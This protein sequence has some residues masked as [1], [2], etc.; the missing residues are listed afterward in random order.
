MK[1]DVEKPLA[2]Y[3]QIKENLLRYLEDERYQTD[4]RLPSESELM[5]H[6]GVSRNT[7]RQAL[8]ELVNEGIIYKK[9]R[10]GSFFSGAIQGA[11]KRSHLIGVITPFLARYIYP[12]IIQGIDDIAHRHHYNLVLGNTRGVLER[13]IATIESLLAKNIDGVLI[14]LSAGFQQIHDSQTFHFVK[15]LTIPLVFL[16]WRIDDPDVSY[17]SVNDVEGGFRATSYLA[18][19]GHTRIACVYPEDHIAALHRYQGYRNALEYYHL[20]YDSRLDKAT[21]VS[22]WDT[23][24]MNTPIQELLDLGDEKPSAIF[25][26]T[27]EMAIQW[28]YPVIRNAGF[29][30]P[31]DISIIGFDG[32]ELGAVADVPLTSVA[33]PKSLVGKWGAQILFEQIECHREYLPKQILITPRISVRESVK[34]LV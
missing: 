22:A 13:E 18:N 26:F 27:D 19:A 5:N 2:K 3:L 29:R 14:E 30:I 23:D 25:F 10:S 4:Q 34:H 9:H 7:V 11:Q 1:H 21:P 31:E 17:V 28:G 20:P 16:N 33:H 24:R 15:N 32:S 8:E 12:Q 6:F